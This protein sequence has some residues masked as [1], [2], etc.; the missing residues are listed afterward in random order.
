MSTTDASFDAIRGAIRSLWPRDELRHVE[1]DAAAGMLLLRLPNDIAAFAVFNGHPDL[2]YPKAY[3]GFKQLYRENSQEWDERTLS[4]VICRSSE[5]AED[6]RFY[7]ALETDPLFCRKYVIRAHNTVVAQR[8]ELLRLPFLPLPTEGEIGLQRPQSAQDL[9]QSVGLSASFARN[10]IETGHRSAERIALDLRDGH[11]SLPAVLSQSRRDDQLQVT[12]PRS[13][14]R[15]VSLTVEGFRAYRAAQTF[16]LDASLVVL[17]GPNGLGKTSVFDAIDYA[18]TGRIGRLCRT[19]RSPSDFARIA[20]HLDKTPGSGSVVVTVR[21]DDTEAREW[22]V[23]RSTGDWGTAWIDGHEAD[24]KTVI[25]KLTQA[26]W[27][28]TTPRQQTLESLFRATHLFSQDEQELLTKFQ[29]GSIIPE[30]FISEMLALQDYSQG[31]AKVGDVLSKLSDH[32]E[33]TEKDLTQLRDESAALTTSMPELA[34]PHST[35]LMPI[36]S[37]IDDL[38]KEMVNSPSALEPLPEASTVMAYTEWYDVALAQSRSAQDRT[39]LAQTL[40]NELP[41]HHSRVREHSEGQA[42]LEDIDRRLQEINQEEQTH[43]QSLEFADAALREE[44]ASERHL[45]QRRRD[46]RSLAEELSERNDLMK[47]VAALTGERDRQL[48]ERS[49]VDAHLAVTESALSNAVSE[50]SETER[51]ALSVQTDATRIELLV[52]ELGQFA[53]DAVIVADIQTRL[54]TAREDLREAEERLAQAD[55]DLQVAKLARE[56]REPE[57]QRAVAAQA[58]IENLLDS[59]QRHVQD[60]SCPLCGS[61]FESAEALLASIRR[62]RESVSP[63]SD[64]TTAYQALLAS[65]M[66]AGDQFRVAAAGVNVAAAA[67]EELAGLQTAADQRFKE[68]R[69]RLTTARITGTHADELRASL[70]ARKEELNDYLAST[71]D[72]AEKAARHVEGLQASLIKEAA[73]R[74]GVQDRV[75]VLERTIQDLADQINTLD[76]RFSQVF[77]G[78]KDLEPSLSTEIA[79]IEK[80]IDAVTASIQRLQATRKDY[81]EAGQALHARRLGLAETR[82][83][84]LAELSALHQSVAA[85]RLK[86]RTLAVSD[87]GDANSLARVTRQETDHTEAIGALAAKALVILTALRARETRL[88]LLETRQKLD[89]LKTSIGEREEQLR[90][91]REGTAICSAIEA[92]LRRERQKA[93]EIHIAAYGPMITMI[94]QRLRSVYGFGGVQLEARGGEARVRVEWRS[95]SVHVPPTDFFSDS[96]RQILMLSIFM[97]GG[98]RQNWSGFAPVLLDDPVTHFDDLNAY[99]FVE[100]IRGIVA[101]S[102]NEWQFIVSTCEQRLFDLMQKKFARMPS[103]AIFYEFIGMTEK[104]PIVERR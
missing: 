45:Q 85:F 71:K 40:Y 78:V 79:S 95:K 64:V 54:A 28:D 31:L 62:Q 11:E 61:R 86:L 74:K 65:E 73:K 29:K 51:A 12:K 23:Q 4:F 91:V 13:T 75:T 25:N 104:G 69:A 67:I 53:R 35:E 3:D 87:D 9:L 89:A 17:Y 21:G 41:T 34:D 63:Y 36:E 46:L 96:Q 88:R 2:D 5:N 15:L 50:A 59:I 83:Q 27:L 10:L 44:E 76:V 56:L 24:R 84:L 39:Q 103:G 20:T 14:S 16:H 82:A 1:L 22:K 100:L 97:A 77:P 90:R 99:A 6:D 101:T 42:Q 72:A 93:I 19:R 38:R 7:A 18:S 26:N 33:T 68:F 94:Q 43:A 48:L 60:E 32:G 81:I 49:K 57:Y 98:L 8:D 80:S 52:Q 70:T 37:T 58:N 47:R 30:A 92:L 66:Q 55:K 102:P